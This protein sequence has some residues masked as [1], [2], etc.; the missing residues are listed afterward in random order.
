MLRKLTTRGILLTT[1][2]ALFLSSATSIAQPDKGDKPVPG[3]DT[4]AS[5]GF[6]DEAA[7]ATSS[8]GT[9]ATPPDSTTP[10]DS[11]SD[12]SSP[13]G[14]SPDSL[15]SLREEYFKLRDRLFQSKARASAVSSA[16]YSTRLSLRL[17]YDSARYYTVTRATIRLDGANI[18]DDSEGTITGDKN[19]PRFEGYIA[20]GRHQLS[21]RIEASGKDDDRFTT[22][23]E[24]SFTV[25][26]VKGE[27]LEVKVSAKD[28][29]DIA[30]KWSRKQRG[31]YKLHLDVGIKSVKR[32]NTPKSKAKKE[33]NLV[34]RPKVK[35][36]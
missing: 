7:D 13:S 15:E 17:G 4:E 12:N 5:E 18:F 9:P 23:I 32:K 36:G 29:G 1:G 30:Y 27:D 35:R 10:D 34:S 25:Q 19:A 26:A 16:L 3:G 8:T 33:A 6:D 22:V 20:P 11:T 21:I 2:L 31:S 24:N 28:G 14:S